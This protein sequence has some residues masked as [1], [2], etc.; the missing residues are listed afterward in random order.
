MEKKDLILYLFCILEIRA[1][2]AF[3]YSYS[4]KSKPLVKY[5]FNIGNRIYDIHSEPDIS[6]LEKP[7]S[8]KLSLFNKLKKQSIHFIKKNLES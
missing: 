4:N 8:L 2:K 7:L 5:I 1:T 3:I 6:L